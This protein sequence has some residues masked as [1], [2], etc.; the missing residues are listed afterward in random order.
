MSL[1]TER[2]G[3]SWDTVHF[4]GMPGQKIVF[5]PFAIYIETAKEQTQYSAGT[6]EHVKLLISDLFRVLWL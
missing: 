2:P 4:D 3:L 6:Q 5:A 1:L